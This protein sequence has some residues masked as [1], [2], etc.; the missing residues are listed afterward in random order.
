MAKKT[1][2][3]G[4]GFNSLL[5]EIKGTAKERI[6]AKAASL[7]EKQKT[8]PRVGRPAAGRT[9]ADAASGCKP[10]EV[11]AAFIANK[12]LLEKIKDIAYWERVMIKEV[13]NR[14]LTKEVQAYERKNPLKK[15]PKE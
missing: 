2:K 13:F 8:K 3:G 7:R 12:D 1:L 10:G 14:A 15:R 5:D 9:D 6:Q 4:S 11:R